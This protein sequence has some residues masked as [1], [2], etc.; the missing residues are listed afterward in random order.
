[1]KS[2]CGKNRYDDVRTDCCDGVTW[3]CS[4]CTTQDIHLCMSPNLAS[5]Y[6]HAVVSPVD[7]GVC[8][9]GRLCSDSFSHKHECDATRKLERI[10]SLLVASRSYCGTNVVID[11]VVELCSS[12]GV[13]CKSC[14]LL[15]ATT[16]INSIVLIL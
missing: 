16:K 15:D 2:F 13:Q 12:L 10:K 6:S 4:S 8:V 11:G 14:N 1:M 9:T 5:M 3:Q 7:A